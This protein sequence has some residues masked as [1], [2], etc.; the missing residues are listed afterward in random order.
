MRVLIA[1]DAPAVRSALEL[2]LNG[3][4]GIE[5]VGEAADWS[6]LGERSRSS[7]PD[8]VLL[9][10]ALPGSEGMTLLPALRLACPGVRVVALG[11][12]PGDRQAALGAGADAFVSK[13]DHPDRLHAALRSLAERDAVGEP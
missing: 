2:A 10:W 9:D 3:H 12:R 11:V 6:A 13:A 7:H 1:D 5:V 4:D 8:V